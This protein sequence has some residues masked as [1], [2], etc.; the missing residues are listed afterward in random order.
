MEPLRG[1]VQNYEWGMRSTDCQAR[2]RRS[3]GESPARPRSCAAA[4]ASAAAW[5]RLARCAALRRLLR[6]GMR[7]AWVRLALPLSCLRASSL[8]GRFARRG[9]RRR[10]G[11]GGAAL[12]RALAGH[13]PQR[14]GDAARR[15]TRAPRA[16]AGGTDATPSNPALCPSLPAQRRAERRSKAGWRRRR[17]S[18]SAP[19]WR[20]AGAETSLS[21]SRRA[22]LFRPSCQA[23]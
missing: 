18:A 8:A 10:R 4:A 11:G 6:R 16:V 14:P 3:R 22:P 7:R 17:P 19:R 20:R 21:F 23:I 15:V 9:Q 2:P 5:P 12:R 1:V 13:A